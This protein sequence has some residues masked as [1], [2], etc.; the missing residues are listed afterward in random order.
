MRSGCYLSLMFVSVCSF[1]LLLC[2]CWLAHAVLIAVVGC[3]LLLIF[4]LIL[5]LFL[6]NM[7]V[8]RPFPGTMTPFSDHSLPTR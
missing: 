8:C 5:L 2:K 4:L 1:V 3:D 7:F 6:L